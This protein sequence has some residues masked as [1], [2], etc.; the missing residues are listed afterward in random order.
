MGVARWCEVSSHQSLEKKPWKGLAGV[1]G[2][3]R[4]SGGSAKSQSEGDFSPTSQPFSPECAPSTSARWTRPPGSIHWLCALLQQVPAFLASCP[5]F[6]IAGLLQSHHFHSLPPL[7][8]KIHRE[9]PSSASAS[10]DHQIRCVVLL[11]SLPSLLSLP[12]NR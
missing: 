7:A 11:P 6:F 10:P 5:R 4:R 1:R 12:V 2:V 8:F 3:R 9:T